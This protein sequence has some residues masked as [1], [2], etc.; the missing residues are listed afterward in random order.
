M[1]LSKKLGVNTTFTRNLT[2]DLMDPPSQQEV[3]EE[4][5]KLHS[6]QTN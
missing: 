6:Q 5:A 4:I 1:A 2:L 3:D